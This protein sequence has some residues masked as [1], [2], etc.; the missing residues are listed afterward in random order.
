MTVVAVSGAGGGAGSTTVAAHLATALAERGVPVLCFDF[1]PNNILRLHF[2]AS[3]NDGTGFA[4]TLPHTANWQSA[5]FTSATN[6]QFLPFGELTNADDLE[7]IQHYLLNHPQWLREGIAGLDLPK[8]TVVICDCPN[9][10]GPLRDQPLGVADLILLVCP[11]DPLS[12]AT[13][14]RIAQ[15]IE[16]PNSGM[17]AILLNRFVA[18]RQLDRDVQMVLNRQR[19]CHKVPVTLHQD[20]TVREALAH[21]QTVFSYAKTSNA[22]QEFD[23]LATW[24]LSHT[25]RGLAAA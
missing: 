13:A 21:K 7:H 2:G 10:P 4:V 14:T 11:P 18:S 24:V 17:C 25:R 6:V 16:S 12:L 5:A 20:E 1:S 15:R 3:L 9:L 8:D 22:A 23:A 19:A